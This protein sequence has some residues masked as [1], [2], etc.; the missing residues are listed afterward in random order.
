MKCIGLWVPLEVNRI[1]DHNINY[2]SRKR[3]RK[4]Q[5]IKS[6]NV[7]IKMWTDGV[8][9]ES[10][11]IDQLRNVANMPFIYKHVA[12]MPDVHIGIGATVGSVIATKGAV[13]PAAVGVDIGCGMVAVKTSL[14]AK[15]LPDNLSLI[16]SEIEKLVPVGMDE[17][18]S[19][20]LLQHGNR[21]AI[22]K[23]IDFHMNKL[24]HGLKNVCDASPAV[25]KMTKNIWEKSYNQIGTLG[26][27]NHFIELC[28]DDDNSVW[29]MLHSGSRGV[30]NCIGRYFIELAKKDMENVIGKLPSADLAYLS[31]GTKHYVEYL[32]AVEW[33]QTYA[34][35]NRLAMMDL[36]I[37]AL[38][39][40]LPDFSL[41]EKAISCHHNYISH[42]M[43]YGEMV[44]VTR[45]G[46]VSAQSGEYGI[47]P[48]SMG[49]KSYIVRGKGNEESFCSCSHGA[50]RRMSRGMA[51]KSITVEDHIAATQGVECRKDSG[52][53]DESPKAYKNI[54][55]VME[56]QRDLVDIVYTL[57][58][59]ICVKG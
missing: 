18:S 2:Y 58:Q 31:E 57:K 5:T 29:I 59:V 51:N 24:S 53:L 21:A 44:H 45:K 37:M 20:R 23:L 36:V 15:D 48:G 3:E 38:K 34:K 46:A 35:H 8:P 47:I 56:A 6:N 17:H 28:L 14:T 43:H 33:A 16:R 4:M 19:S 32:N 12:V 1:A 25:E 10:G 52:V 41:T 50:G 7:D 27:G 40:F 22:T 26:S 11:A 49:A 55:S 54:E 13:I 30:G 42:E 9:V 39:K